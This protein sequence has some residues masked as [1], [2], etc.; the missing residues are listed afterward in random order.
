MMKWNPLYIQDSINYTMM[1]LSKLSDWVM[2]MMLMIMIS[3]MWFYM[4]VI[5]NN[6]IT[7]TIME[8]KSIEFMWTSLPLVILC[9]M[10]SISMKTLYAE[11]PS[12]QYPAMNLLSTGHQWY[13]EYYYPDFNINFDSFLLSW[14]KDMY[15]NMEC[16]NRVMLPLYTPIRIAV[17]SADVIHSWSMPSMGIKLDATP[18]RVISTAHQSTIPGL[19]YGFC[20]ELCGVNHSYMPITVEH[21][22]ILL[23]KNWLMSQDM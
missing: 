4:G 13:W 7:N 19:S 12:N 17:T 10:A 5:L 21:T 6:F 8:H 11:E 16:D 20:A 2:T 23:F 22:S 14:E 15:R 9:L 1:S 3:V 18:G